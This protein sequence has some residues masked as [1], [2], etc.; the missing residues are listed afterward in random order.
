MPLRSKHF[1]QPP[2]QRFQD[3]LLLDSKHIAPGAKGE[4]VR[5]I[6]IA[7]NRLTEGPGRENI[8][9]VMD[10]IYGSKTAAAVKQYKDTRKILQPWQSSADEVVGKKTMQ[11]LD[12]EMSVLEEE[13]DSFS[14][15]ISSNF[16][17]PRHDHSKCPPPSRDPEIEIA[18]DQTMS[19]L[20]TPMNPLGFGRMINIGGVFE[21]VGFEDFVPDPRLDPSMKGVPVKHRKLT[22]TIPK[23]TVS[24]ICFRSA[25]LD[26]FMEGEIKRICL[27]S[28]RLTFVGDINDPA[29]PRLFNYFRTLGLFV[30]S[31]QISDKEI[32]SGFRSYVVVSVVNVNP[33]SQD[34][35]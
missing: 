35:F 5:R 10:G 26:A 3:C 27:P 12:D 2:D 22:S 15:L 17:G 8:F 21:A 7:I 14:G 11:S 32:K 4:H 24:D 31:G 34:P 23:H 16:I 13:S 20:A 9:L 6:Q 18:P 25:P 28:A 30:E 33:P 1:T 29:S 19:H